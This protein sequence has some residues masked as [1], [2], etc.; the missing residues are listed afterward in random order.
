MEDFSE[1]I[2]P[3]RQFVDNFLADRLTGSKDAYAFGYDVYGTVKRDLVQQGFDKSDEG[4][5]M[6]AMVI[7]NIFFAFVASKD[8]M[9]GIRGYENY[10]PEY[11]TY[12]D[13]DNASSAI[14]DALANKCTGVEADELYKILNGIRGSQKTAT[15]GNLS[16]N[17]F[18]Y[19]MVSHYI[20][21]INDIICSKDIY[22]AENRRK[23]GF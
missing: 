22:T 5:K 11:N 8:I 6:L 1:I 21:N 4:T 14:Y 2:D 13:L 18:V 16:L 3:K 20:N 9:A 17:Q 23:R 7:T 12:Y 19:P 15:I 10:I